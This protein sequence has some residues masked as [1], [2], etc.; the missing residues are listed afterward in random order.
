[1]IDL[2]TKNVVKYYMP[3]EDSVSEMADRFSAYAD[4]L[5][6]KVISAL[7]VTELCVSD[8]ASLLAV[9]QSTLS[10]GLRYLLDRK[11]VKK[12]RRG[13]VI[14][15]SLYSDAVTKVMNDVLF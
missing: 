15:Y 4:E 8:M 10:H 9:N 7:A 6:L 5:R 1:M 11:I 14:M 2:R 12:K 3:D 13:K